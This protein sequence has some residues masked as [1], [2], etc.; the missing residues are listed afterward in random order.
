MKQTSR[1]TVI[2]EFLSIWYCF[3]TK[4]L[5]TAIYKKYRR[6]FSTSFIFSDNCQLL[7]EETVHSSTGTYF[8][9]S[10]SFRLVETSFL[11]TR[12]NSVFFR[13]FSACGNYC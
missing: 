11:S 12:N 8:P 3:F 5:G 2:F 7:L 4:I 10:P 1:L 13:V 6:L 9:V